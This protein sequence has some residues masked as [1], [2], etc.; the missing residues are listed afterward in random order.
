[1]SVVSIGPPYRAAKAT[2]SG[3]VSSHWAPCS[4]QRA[5]EWTT[6]KLHVNS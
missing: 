2:R 4:A 5:M 3:E 6:A 1:M